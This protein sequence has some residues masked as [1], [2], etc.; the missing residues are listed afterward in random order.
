M[1]TKEELI[2]WLRDAYAM[3]KAMETA[4]KK[5]INNEK[6]PMKARELASIHF[7]ETEG[8]AE[9]VHACLHNLGADVST[10]KTALAQGLE[11]AKG[12]GTMFARDEHIKDILAA[13][14]SEHFE[15][16]CYTAL[17]TAAQEL[18]ITAV[19]ETCEAILREEV[20]MA[21]K[22]QANL[23]DLIKSYLRDHTKG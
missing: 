4:L 12:F 3:E 18:G 7:T 10:L 1:K 23:P 6:L 14:A 20:S 13:Y 15:I 9:A 5:Q 19:E 11:V 2:D 21:E 22:L 8:H 16:A 17:I